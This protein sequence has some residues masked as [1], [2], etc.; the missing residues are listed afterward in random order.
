MSKL[1]LVKRVASKTGSSQAEASNAVDAVFASIQDSLVAGE[2][3]TIVGF[4]KFHVTRRKA[5]TGRN[6]RTGEPI[7]IAA[8]NQA[9]FSAGKGL[10]EAIN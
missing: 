6:P 8:A 10:K 1:E 7:Q 4:G 5:T 9:K 2:A 3:I